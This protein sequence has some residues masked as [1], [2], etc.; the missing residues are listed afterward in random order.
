MEEGYD[1][2]LSMLA[3]ASGALETGYLW[4]VDIYMREAK[5]E[6]L[7]H[8]GVFIPHFLGKLVCNK[9]DP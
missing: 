6:L 5:A 9:I 2:S 8:V 1:D 7:L 3:L 4:V